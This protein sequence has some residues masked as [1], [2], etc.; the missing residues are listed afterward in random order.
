MRC[1]ISTA[2]GVSPPPVWAAQWVRMRCVPSAADLRTSSICPEVA[3][4]PLHVIEVLSGPGALALGE[5]EAQVEQ[6]RSSVR[7]VAVGSATS[8][9]LRGGWARGGAI[10][11]YG[12]EYA[13]A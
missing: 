12:R 6:R 5:L 8:G 3:H 4:L 13:C 9:K 1:F 10:R 7:D 2:I 11:E